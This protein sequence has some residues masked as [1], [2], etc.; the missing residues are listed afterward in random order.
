MRD[1]GAFGR[2]AT[3]WLRTAVSCNS[4]NLVVKARAR[5][6]NVF[7]DIIESREIIADAAQPELQCVH[8]MEN[9]DSFSMRLCTA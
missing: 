5:T 2:T 6:D 1:A 4:R 9:I 7:P 8:V 3:Q